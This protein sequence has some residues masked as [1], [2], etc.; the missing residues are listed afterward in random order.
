MVRG[1]FL[2]WLGGPWFGGFEGLSTVGLVTLLLLTWRCFASEGPRLPSMWAR[3]LCSLIQFL[4]LARFGL[5][6]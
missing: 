6:F 3:L 5:L 2:G 1:L 4:A